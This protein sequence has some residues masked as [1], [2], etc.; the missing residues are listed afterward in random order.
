MVA[1]CDER[2]ASNGTRISPAVKIHEYIK[3]LLK[4]HKYKSSLHSNFLIFKYAT[5]SF[6]YASALHA[7]D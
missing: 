5:V 7:Y 4:I 6:G 2:R 1:S 3:L